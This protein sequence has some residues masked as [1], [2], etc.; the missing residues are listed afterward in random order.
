MDYACVPLQCNDFDGLRLEGWPKLNLLPKS[1]MLQRSVTCI[2]PRCSKW[3]SGCVSSIYQL[4]KKMLSY[5]RLQLKLPRVGRFFKIVPAKDHSSDGIFC[6]AQSRNS[7]LLPLLFILWGV[8]GMS[9]P[10]RLEEISV[11]PLTLLIMDVPRQTML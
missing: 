3:M 6:R 10:G 7:L 4:N 2:W 9:Y 5:G 1:S 11:F 8:L